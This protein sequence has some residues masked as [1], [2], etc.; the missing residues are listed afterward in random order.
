MRDQIAAV[1]ETLNDEAL[2]LVA[3]FKDP[4]KTAPLIADALAALAE[5]GLVQREGEH[6]RMAGSRSG[7]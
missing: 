2:T 3:G 5:L 4:K 7:G 1:R 6:Y